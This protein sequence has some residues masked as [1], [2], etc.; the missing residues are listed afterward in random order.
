MKKFFLSIPLL[1]FSIFLFAQKTEILKK[2]GLSYPAVNPDLE[3]G[4][5]VI[6]SLMDV[7]GLRFVATIRAKKKRSSYLASADVMDDVYAMKFKIEHLAKNLGANSF[8]I[9]NYSVNDSSKTVSLTVDAYLSSDSM[10]KIN[11]RLETKNRLY[12]FPPDINYHSKP[13]RFKFN[14][15]WISLG[16]REYFI[17]QLKPGETVVV[18]KGIYKKSIWNCPGCAAAI[19]NYE[20]F[21]WSPV[22]ATPEGFVV[23][24][25]ND[26]KIFMETFFIYPITCHGCTLPL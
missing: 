16:P 14:N 8:R 6:D 12:V 5:P 17:Y 18:A 11:E 4:F 13:F 9:T 10:L 19:L 26:K 3:A 2:S 21:S 24:P 25:E 23:M 20:R 15:E 7:S 22:P 1:I